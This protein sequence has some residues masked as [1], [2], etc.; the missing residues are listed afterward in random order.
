MSELAKARVRNLAFGTPRGIVR[1][2]TLP[3]SRRAR[4]RHAGAIR[5]RVRPTRDERQGQRNEVHG[6]PRNTPRQCDACIVRGRT[7][8]A[9]RWRNK[10]P[11]AQGGSLVASPPQHGHSRQTIG[12]LSRSV[13]PCAAN[14]AKRRKRRTSTYARLQQ[15]PCSPTHVMPALSQIKRPPCGK[16]EAWLEAG[17]SRLQVG[18]TTAFV[19]HRNT[20][21]WRSPTSR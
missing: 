3:R 6:R 16:S 10:C 1:C 14:A 18:S 19:M 20:G 9:L 21:P 12:D 2:P 17:D 4:R 7:A 5:H 13:M 15:R 8:Q 11:R